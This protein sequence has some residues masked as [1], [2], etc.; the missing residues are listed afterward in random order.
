[1][2]AAQIFFLSP[3]GAE[4]GEDRGEGNPIAGQSKAPPLPGP[5]LH[6]MEERE[7]IWLELSR[8][9]AFPA[10][11]RRGVRDVRVRRRPKAG[12]HSRAMFLV[13]GYVASLDQKRR[14]PRILQTQSPSIS[15]FGSTWPP[16]SLRFQPTE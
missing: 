16:S 8:A 6:P 7:F 2:Q 9:A 4:R 13:S 1:M 5:L 11:C 15:F 3:R 10:S 12:E 14:G